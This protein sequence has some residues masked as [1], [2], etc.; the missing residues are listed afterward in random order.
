M[1]AGSTSTRSVPRPRLDFLG[2]VPKKLTGL[3][4]YQARYDKYDVANTWENVTMSPDFP[5]VA[6]AIVQLYPQSG[7]TKIDGVIEVG[8]EAMAGLLTLTGPVHVPGLS[9]ALD[10][11]NVAKF[12]LHDEYTLVTDQNERADLLGNIAPLDLRQAHV[13]HVGADRRRSPGS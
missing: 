4:D 9:F 10:S 5:T 12:L 1:T 11:Q 13:R 2:V 6:Q 8:P 7:G 3:V